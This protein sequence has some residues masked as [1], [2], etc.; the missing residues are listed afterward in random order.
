MPLTWWPRLMMTT[1]SLVSVAIVGLV[2]A[3]AVNAFK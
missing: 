1:Q 3:R 2:N